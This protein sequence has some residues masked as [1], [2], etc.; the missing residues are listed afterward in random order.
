M[1]G[2]AE[3]AQILDYSNADSFISALGHGLLPDLEQ[4]D[5]VAYHCGSAGRPHQQRWRRSRLEEL[6]ARRPSTP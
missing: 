4:P 1:V 3:A 5:G 2:A 6:A